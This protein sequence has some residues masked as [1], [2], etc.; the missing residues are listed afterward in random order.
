[1]LLGRSSSKLTS[2][3]PFF[4]DIVFTGDDAVL[5]DSALDENYITDYS[6]LMSLG[7]SLLASL[8]ENI[9]LN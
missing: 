3:G 9:G 7:D 6:Q 4:L 5:P 2:S 8:I 1:M